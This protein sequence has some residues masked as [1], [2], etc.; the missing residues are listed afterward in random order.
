MCGGVLVIAITNPA[1]HTCPPRR[2]ERTGA[3]STRPFDEFLRSTEI[4]NPAVQPPA[5]LWQ[6]LETQNLQRP[7]QTTVRG[8]MIDVLA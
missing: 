6:V 4:V 5:P 2:V 7:H 8:R 3:P 1:L